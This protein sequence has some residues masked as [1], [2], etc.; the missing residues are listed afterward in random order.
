[1]SAPIAVIALADA[2]NLSSTSSIS[3]P[4]LAAAP[5]GMWAKASIS[6]LVELAREAGEAEPVGNAA[7]P[8]GGRVQGCPVQTCAHP[9][10]RLLRPAGLGSG[11]FNVQTQIYAT[12]EETA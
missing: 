11:R 7:R 9:W 8:A 2:A 12:F 6:S 3:S 1:M 5:V 10:P 4:L